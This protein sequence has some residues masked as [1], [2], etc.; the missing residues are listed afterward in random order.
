VQGRNWHL[1]REAMRRV[2]AVASQGRSLSHS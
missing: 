2:V 1:S